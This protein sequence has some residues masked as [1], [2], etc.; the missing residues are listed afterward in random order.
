MDFSED[1]KYTKKEIKNIINYHFDYF[2]SGSCRGGVVPM[3]AVS[4]TIAAMFDELLIHKEIIDELLY[5]PY[6]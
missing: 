5:T 3:G 1:R 6:K 4:V 2:L